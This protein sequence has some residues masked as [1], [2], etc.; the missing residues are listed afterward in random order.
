MTEGRPVRIQLLDDWDSTNFYALIAAI[1]L[2]ENPLARCAIIVRNKELALATCDKLREYNLDAQFCSAKCPSDPSRSIAVCAPNSARRALHGQYFDTKVIGVAPA[3]RYCRRFENIPGALSIEVAP[4]FLHKNLE[5]DYC[6]PMEQAYK[7]GK[8]ASLQAFVMPL[9]F[10]RPFDGLVEHVAEILRV[11][12]DW[13]PVAVFFP[14]RHMA[15]SS[16][17]RLRELNISAAL[18][19]AFGSTKRLIAERS[20][21]IEETAQGQLQVLIFGAQHQAALIPEAVRSIVVVSLSKYVS[22][23]A[24]LYTALRTCRARSCRILR[25]CCSPEEI[26]AATRF[27]AMSF[28]FFPGE[29]RSRDL[30]L[31][32]ISQIFQETS[33]ASFDLLKPNGEITAATEENLWKTIAQQRNQT[34]NQTSKEEDRRRRHERRRRYAISRRG[35]PEIAEMY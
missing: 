35:T 27:A 14:R 16:I 24:G 15:F 2:K 31:D 22:L 8:V 7:D 12:S 1:S 21:L 33:G 9:L 20:R 23:P 28:P 10:T 3:F 30:T 5:T 34:T 13:A 26:G 18:W 32:E 11:Q 17:A 4:T 29:R 6:Y 25:I 19:P